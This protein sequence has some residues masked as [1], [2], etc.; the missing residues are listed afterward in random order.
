M[1]TCVLILSHLVLLM[2]KAFIFAGAE[3]A[4]DDDDDDDD[5]NDEISE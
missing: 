2:A 5:D 1:L 3:F 4:D